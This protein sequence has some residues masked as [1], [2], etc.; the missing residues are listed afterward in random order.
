M[1]LSET[2]FWFKGQARSQIGFRIYGQ[3][4]NRVGNVADFGHPRLIFPGEL[5]PRGSLL[6]DA[7]GMLLK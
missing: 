2:G 1:K 5:P 4:I 7:Y 6:S 3:G